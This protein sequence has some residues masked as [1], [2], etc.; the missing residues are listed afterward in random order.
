[1]LDEDRRDD[2]ASEEQANEE[3]QNG[4][5]FLEGARREDV[6]CTKRDRCNRPVLTSQVLIGETLLRNI[7]FDVPDTCSS[8]Q[9][10]TSSGTRRSLSNSVPRATH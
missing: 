2:C 10:V 8:V 6:G 5:E 7:N 1:M 4:E 9:P 3:D